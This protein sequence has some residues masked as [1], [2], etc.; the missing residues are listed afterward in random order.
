MYESMECCD[1]GHLVA[2]VDGWG[3]DS[4]SERQWHLSWDLIGEKDV[5]LEHSRYGTSFRCWRK[6]KE[7]IVSEAEYRQWEEKCR[8][9]WKRSDRP[10]TERWVTDMGFISLC[11]KR[12]PNIL[13]RAM[14]WP[15]ITGLEQAGAGWQFG[16]WLMRPR[17][18]ICDTWHSYAKS[19]WGM[20]TVWQQWRQ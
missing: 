3:S 4:L 17:S 1:P 5:G 20:D 8:I 18:E 14:T 19:R 16:E 10:G 13:N 11:E 9:R 12:P 2:A 6:R 7:T 15:D